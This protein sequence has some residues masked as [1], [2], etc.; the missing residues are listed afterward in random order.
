MTLSIVDFLEK[1]LQD[2]ED[3]ARRMEAVYPTPWDLYDRGWMVRI[4][5]GEPGWHEVVRLEQKYAPEGLEWLAGAIEHVALQAPEQTIRRIEATR[6]LLASIYADKHYV[7][8]DPWYTC[9]A[10]T[11]ERDGGTYAET[12]GG[13]SC[14]CGRDDRVELQLR[15]L[16]SVYPDCPEEWRP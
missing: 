5:A 16:A 9:Q 4:Q 3:A 1:Q 11:D 7:C 12:G 6:A 13:G 15:H 10:A 8:D 2:E 14:D